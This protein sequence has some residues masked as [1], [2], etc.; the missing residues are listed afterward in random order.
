MVPVSLYRF[1]FE[2]K[3]SMY[4]STPKISKGFNVASSVI[5][6]HSPKTKNY[7]HHIVHESDGED[8]VVTKLIPPEAQLIALSVASSIDK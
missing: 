6:L 5:L 2:I 7:S 8:D 4:L 3:K 1:D